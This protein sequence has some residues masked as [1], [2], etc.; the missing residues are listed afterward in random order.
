M[1]PEKKIWEGGTSMRKIAAMLFAAWFCLLTLSACVKPGEFESE[2]GSPENEAKFPDYVFQAEQ[3]QHSAGKSAAVGAGGY[4]FV[5][6]RIL[7][8][9]QIDAEEAFPLCTKTSCLHKDQTC[10]AFANGYWITEQ[11]QEKYPL[12]CFGYHMIPDEACLYMFSR[13]KN[14]DLYL[15]R[16][17]TDFTDKETLAKLTDS[18]AEPRKLTVADP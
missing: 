9:Y 1:D 18:T 13:D 8:F 16:Y 3:A 15:D 7:Y 4:Y 14:Y 2:S 17:G 10:N 6:D 5:A 12:N 11:D